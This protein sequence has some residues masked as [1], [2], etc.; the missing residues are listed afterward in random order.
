[1]GG[2]WDAMGRC[3][4]QMG[5]CR[6]AIGQ[7]RDQMGGCRDA[8][9]QWRDQMGGCWDAIG[10][11][12]RT[13]RITG[14]AVRFTDRQVDWSRR[15]ARFYMTMDSQR[16]GTGKKRVQT[17]V[18]GRIPRRSSGFFTRYHRY[19]IKVDRRTIFVGNLPIKLALKRVSQ[20]SFSIHFFYQ[21][22]KNFTCYTVAFIKTT[23]E[24]YPHLCPHRKNRIC[25][26][27]FYTI[28]NTYI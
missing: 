12:L 3:R 20:I 4:D 26:V 24:A 25:T 27:P 10:L 9:G 21:N 1:M 6:D 13:V 16:Y 14:T 7:W 28:P 19:H 17:A 23:T 11:G 15:T 22:K 18:Y 5:G 8:I 2:C